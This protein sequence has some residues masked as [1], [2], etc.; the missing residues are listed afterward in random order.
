MNSF[1][2]MFSDIRKATVLAVGFH[3]L[4]ILLFFLWKINFNFNP[5]EYSEIAFIAST[6]QVQPAKTKETVKPQ[7]SR[8]VPKQQAP[9]PKEATTETPENAVPVE[10]PKRRMLE[11]EPP[12]IAERQADKLAPAQ[13]GE[14][15]PVR[16]EMQNDQR[17]EVPPTSSTG[18]KISPGAQN[19]ALSG[20]KTSPTSENIS[21]G[22]A[23]TQ[24]YTIEGEAADRTVLKKVI[25]EY[26]E[27]LQKEAVVKIRF[28]VLPDGRVGQ[29]IPVQKDAPQ[30]ENVTME[31][32]RQWRF[33]PLSPSS[34][35]RTVQ[36][37]ITFRYELK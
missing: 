33:N 26:P 13:E 36:G 32:L 17:V 6:E 21:G 34:E 11:Q 28:S 31:A 23:Q 7:P 4:L 35:Q 3:L 9:T 24:P 16:R 19:L 15:L 12:E 18:E 30:L 5:P 27:N 14:K 25:P 10:L 37:V 8:A 1:I 2:D 29:M 20:A 22:T